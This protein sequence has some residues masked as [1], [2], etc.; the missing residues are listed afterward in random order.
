MRG[1]FQ[2]ILNARY[3]NIRPDVLSMPVV[4]TL[5]QYSTFVAGTS[6][7]GNV[8]IEDNRGLPWIYNAD[9]GCFV[10]GNERFVRPMIAD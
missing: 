10:R 4:D 5:R 9:E 6:P 3:R 2:A 1:S 8:L 7:V